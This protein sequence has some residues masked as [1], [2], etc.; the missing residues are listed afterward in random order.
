[1]GLFMF[2]HSCFSIQTGRRQTSRLFCKRGRGFEIETTK[3]KLSWRSRRNVD[4]GLQVQR[5]NRSA[6]SVNCCNGRFSYSSVKQIDTE[7][8]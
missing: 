6:T 4:L 2:Q 1:M 7:A 8:R 5:P 3:N